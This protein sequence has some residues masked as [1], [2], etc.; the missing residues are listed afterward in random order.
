LIPA[1][2][3]VVH[4]DIP[5]IAIRVVFSSKLS[6]DEAVSRTRPSMDRH[7]QSI[8]SSKIIRWR[9]I[10]D[11]PL[12]ESRAIEPRTERI[13]SKNT[14]GLKIAG[15][16]RRAHGVTCEIHDRCGWVRAE[17]HVGFGVAVHNIWKESKDSLTRRG[18]QH[19]SRDL[20]A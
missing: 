3:I 12:N 18:G 19:G 10:V 8:S 14:D 2:E 9:H 16:D 13:E 20:A 6:P 7:I 17:G 4:H 11:E 15:C 1:V 5:L